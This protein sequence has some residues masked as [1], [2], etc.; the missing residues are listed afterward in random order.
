MRTLAPTAA[1]ASGRRGDTT[2]TVLIVI[3]AVG[4]VLL[5]SC[6]GIGVAGYFWF[7]RNFGNAVVSDPV[8]IRAITTELADITIPAEFQPVGAS[9]IFGMNIVH[10]QWCPAGNCPTWADLD[11][12]TDMM[13]GELGTLTLTTFV[14]EDGGEAE[15]E[16]SVESEF[17]EE[18]LKAEFRNHTKEVKEFTIG[19]KVC[20]FFIVKGEEIPWEDME[21]EDMAESASEA[22]AETPAESV[23]ETPVESSEPAPVSP[24]ATEPV[25]VDP[26]ATPAEPAADAAPP[27]KPG[28]EIVRVQG[29]FPGKKGN[30][31]LNLQLPVAD[32]DETKILQM[33]QSIR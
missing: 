6:L 12:D 31:S 16:E 28:R 33:L 3:A 4:G 29:V 1:P 5:L 11:E 2:Q 25:A 13:G 21:D 14:M 27:G 9:Q 8:K 32:Y 26:A 24:A 10:Y 7:Q 30:C 23:A 17:S 22:A 20:K 15:S 18:N 19:G